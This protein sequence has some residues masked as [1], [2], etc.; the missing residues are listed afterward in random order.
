MDTPTGVSVDLQTKKV[1]I[2][3]K[4]FFLTFP[5]NDVS[6]E[7]ALNRLKEKFE[8]NIKW[9]LIAQ[10]KHKD[11]EKH[12]HIGIEFY[13]TVNVQRSEF[14][15]FITGKHGSYQ[16][17][18][19]VEGTIKYLHKED[20]PISFG[21][22]PSLKKKADSK[23]TQIAKKIQ[24]GFHKRQLELED[25][26]FFMMNKRKIDEYF[27]Y[28]QRQKIKESKPKVLSIKYEPTPDVS[29]LT[30]HCTKTIVEWLSLNLLTPRKFKQ[31]QLYLHGSH[32][33]RKTSLLIA[34]R[35]Y[36]AVY[37]LPHEDF[38]DEYDDEVYDLC[39]IDEFKGNKTIQFLN[40]F[41]QGSE[42]PLRKKGSQA[43]KTQNIP[44]IIVSNYPLHECYKDNEKIQTL[45]TRL[46]EIESI[47][48]ID[49]DGIKFEV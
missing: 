32:D 3:S 14:W 15:D 40:E 9:I 48:V 45:K 46:I 11:G 27:S 23:S 42:M 37:A 19:S 4:K 10:E 2:R 26:G 43:L 34:I 8:D 36:F 28:V 6:K 39:T 24:E 7:E 49:I 30:L 44:T 47:D 41:L 21:E 25:P 12:L 16:V 22:V 35:K 1:R 33:K 17:M 38:Y 18:R 31:A 13:E 29:E 5:Q 20:T